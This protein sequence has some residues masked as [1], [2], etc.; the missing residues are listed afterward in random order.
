MANPFRGEV[1]LRLIDGRRFDLRLTLG[2]LAELETA[3]GCDS[4]SG[5]AARFENGALRADDVI[6]VIAAGLR[7]GGYRD[8][9]EAAGA[10]EVEGGAAGAVAVAARLLRA[11]FTGAVV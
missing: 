6:A 10:L 9:A 3:L 2:A 5:L 8:E 11:G 1:A 4:L 7:G